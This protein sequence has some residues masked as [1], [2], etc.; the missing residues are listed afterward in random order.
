MF[1]L[2]GWVL[3]IISAMRVDSCRSLAVA[4]V[5]WGM[6]GTA[7]GAAVWLDS[8]VRIPWNDFL[9]IGGYDWVWFLTV[10]SGFLGTAG[11][12]CAVKAF[13]GGEHVVDGLGRWA[14]MVAAAASF[15][16]CCMSMMLGWVTVGSLGPLGG[17]CEVPVAFWRS[18]G[19]V[20]GVA[21]SACFWCLLAFLGSFDEPAVAVVEE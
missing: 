8:W 15:A 2:W 7:F 3:G 14:W 12:W 21:G 6:A 5:L 9:G 19:V 4:V 11:C 1:G 13:M 17:S 20:A 16:C 10:L 18:V